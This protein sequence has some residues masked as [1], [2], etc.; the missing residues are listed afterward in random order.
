MKFVKTQLFTGTESPKIGQWVKTELGQRGQYLGKTTS[1]TIV[2]R[3]QHSD[4]VKFSRRD[5]VN[6]H[7]LRAFAKQYGAK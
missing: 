1:G 2:V 3:W 6:N 7:H 4:G 5:A